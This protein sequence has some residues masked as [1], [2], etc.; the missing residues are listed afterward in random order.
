MYSESGVPPAGPNW[1]LGIADVLLEKSFTVLAPLALLAEY[2]AGL[3]SNV[4]LKLI[5]SP[6]IG[7]VNA[8]IVSSANVTLLAPARLNLQGVLTSTS[9]YDF[10]EK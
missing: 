2:L 6:V 4:S 5:V 8:G 1:E 7:L 9:P 3:K 10:T